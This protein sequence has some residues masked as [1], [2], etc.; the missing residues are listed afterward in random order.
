[1]DMRNW[2]DEKHRSAREEAEG[3]IAHGGHRIRNITL[4]DSLDEI[5]RMCAILERMRALL[6]EQKRMRDA[7]EHVINPEADS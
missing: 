2:T 1:M 6:D 5:E 4:S 3:F 7:L